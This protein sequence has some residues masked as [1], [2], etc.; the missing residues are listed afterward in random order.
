ME[1]YYGEDSV[2]GMMEGAEEDEE[3]ARWAA[4]PWTARRGQRGPAGR[5]AHPVASVRLHLLQE[6]C[7]RR[8][9]RG[10]L[11]GPACD[12]RRGKD[13]LGGAR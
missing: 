2:P 6:V 5:R 11:H 1:E 4:S 8:L 13:A 3:V 9:R 7:A 12:E 10:V